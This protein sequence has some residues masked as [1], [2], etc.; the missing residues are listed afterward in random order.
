M[1]NAPRIL[2]QDPLDFEDGEEMEQHLEAML[3]YEVLFHVED[4]FFKNNSDLTESDFAIQRISS[5]TIAWANCW[6][7]FT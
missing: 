5:D 4:D 2:F 6:V 3:E 1:D 7:A